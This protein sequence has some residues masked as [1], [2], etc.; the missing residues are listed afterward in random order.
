MSLEYSAATL[1]L[2]I[3]IK[4]TMPMKLI[5]SLGQSTPIRCWWRYQFLAVCGGDAE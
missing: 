1:L 3:T 5:L 2:T 4:T